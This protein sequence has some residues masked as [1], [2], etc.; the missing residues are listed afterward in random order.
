MPADQVAA[1]PQ[2]ALFRTAD[3]KLRAGNP[4]L[5]AR[6]STDKHFQLNFHTRSNR[7]AE[8]WRGARTEIRA[9][10]RRNP[11]ELERSV[12]RAARRFVLNQHNPH[13][14]RRTGNL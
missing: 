3:E 7:P 14:D 12:H 6:T 11:L 4:D 1:G 13:S 8:G 10:K 9:I 5:L 2:M